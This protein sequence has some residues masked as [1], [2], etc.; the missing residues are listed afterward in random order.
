M[1]ISTAAI[2]ILGVKIVSTVT[3]PKESA[4]EIRSP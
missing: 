4:D 2:S 1:E 3:V